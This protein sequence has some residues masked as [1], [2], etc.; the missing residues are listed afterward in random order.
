[1]ING[2]KGRSQTTAIG[3]P[4]ATSSETFTASRW[5]RGNFWF[6]ARIEV[7]PERVLRI[8]PKFF[9][10]TEEN[11]PINKFASVQISTGMIFPDIRIDSAGGT[12]PHPEPRPS[13]GRR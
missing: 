10:S 12:N 5:P 8:K 2:T 7:E 13:Q 1:M 9:G 11:I 3:F 6:P 4:D